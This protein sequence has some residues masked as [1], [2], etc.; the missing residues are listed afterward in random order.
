[1]DRE[2]LKAGFQRAALR[3]IPFPL[4]ALFHITSYR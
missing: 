3:K 4:L 2:V 1:V